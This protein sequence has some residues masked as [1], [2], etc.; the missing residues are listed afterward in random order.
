MIQQLERDRVAVHKGYEPRVRISIL[1]APNAPAHE[2]AVFTMTWGVA[3]DDAFFSGQS[4]RHAFS[5]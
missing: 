2:R 1:T 4:T 3:V 5:R